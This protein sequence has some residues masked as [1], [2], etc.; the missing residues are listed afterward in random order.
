MCPKCKD[1][2]VVWK[3]NE[4][5]GGVY[6]CDCPKGMDGKKRE[7]ELERGIYEPHGFTR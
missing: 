2:G 1:S 3:A 6:W 5:W 4:V 7:E